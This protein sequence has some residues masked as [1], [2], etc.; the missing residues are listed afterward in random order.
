MKF[1]KAIRDGI[2]IGVEQNEMLLG[3]IRVVLE[4][5]VD[6]CGLSLS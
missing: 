2:E 3:W 1:W 4:V 6:T 5:G